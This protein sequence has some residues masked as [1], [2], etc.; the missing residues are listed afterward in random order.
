MC[1]RFSSL[2]LLFHFHLYFSPS[3]FVSSSCMVGFINAF[4]KCNEQKLCFFF[5]N[6]LRRAFVPDFAPKPLISRVVFLKGIGWGRHLWSLFSLPTLTDT[7]TV[8]VKKDSGHSK[9]ICYKLPQCSSFI[10][11]TLCYHT[12][13]THSRQ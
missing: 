7:L 5:L 3:L 12:N 2:V 8:L 10:F 9:R 11:C 1:V 4:F 13:I 6:L